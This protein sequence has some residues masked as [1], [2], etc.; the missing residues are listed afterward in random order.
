MRP[1]GGF[2]HG[3]LEHHR[4]SFLPPFQPKAISPCRRWLT[5]WC[6]KKAS[7]P[8]PQSCRSSSS[9][10]GSALKK[11]LRA[12]EQDRHELA[13]ARATGTKPQPIMRQERGRL[14]FVDE[15]GTDAKM[16]RLRGRSLKGERLDG[17][18]PFGH[19][20]RQTFVAGLRSDGYV[21]SLDR[22]CA[23]ELGH[24][25]HLCGDTARPRPQTWRC[26]HP[27][28]PLQSKSEQAK[29]SFEAGAHGCSS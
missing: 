20:G 9:P 24:I 18:A 3:K 29:K 25:Q 21:E 17:K 16:T 26:R 11:T 15:S 4:L 27:R 1:R 23:D 28:Q 6:R 19:W 22:Q 10:V 8:I 12:S 7:S 14:I 13:K 5:S 2:R